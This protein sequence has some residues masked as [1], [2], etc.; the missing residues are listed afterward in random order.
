[1]KPYIHAQNSVKRW[2]GKIDDYLPIHDFF[3]SSK[4]H[5]PDMRHRAILHSSFG[6]YIVERVFGTYITNS[7]HKVVQVRDIGDPH[8]IDDLGRI[9]TV[10]DYLGS[11]PYYDWLGGPKTMKRHVAMQDEPNDGTDP[12]P[13]DKTSKGKSA[14]PLSVQDTKPKPLTIEEV[15]K[16]IDEH[17][18]QYPPQPAQP[19]PGM[20][21]N[22]IP[23][24]ENPRPPY[25]PWDTTRIID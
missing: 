3:D 12:H 4:A 25:N 8:V 11:M 14:D 19:Y 21:D 5:V 6:I 15:R 13:A 7:D 10:Q 20:P 22:P 9:P 23:P 24:Y 16:L 17:N 18:K 2:G 1:M